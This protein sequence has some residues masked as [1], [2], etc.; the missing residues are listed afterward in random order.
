MIV[1]KIKDPNGDIFMKLLG[2][3]V[4][5]IVLIIV[6]G[7]IYLNVADVKVTQ[8]EVSKPIPLGTH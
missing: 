1:T 4:G 8:T 7:F 2:G 5:L 3:L 6:V